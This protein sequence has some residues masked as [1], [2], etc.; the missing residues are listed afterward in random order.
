MAPSYLDSI[1]NVQAALAA[2]GYF[3][4]RSLATKKKKTGGK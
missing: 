4:E 1:D 3:S 2:H